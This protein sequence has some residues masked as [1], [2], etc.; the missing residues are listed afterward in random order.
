VVAKKKKKKYKR[1]FKIS[2]VSIT[3]RIEIKKG[4]QIFI[5]TIKPTKK[6]ERLVL[7]LFLKI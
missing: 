1:P 2:A 6:S 4:G 3:L 7:N 5:P